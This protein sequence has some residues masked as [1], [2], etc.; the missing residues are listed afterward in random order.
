MRIADSRPMSY[1]NEIDQAMSNHGK[2]LQL[3]FLLLP[4]TA[5]ELYGA[6]K[7]KCAVDYGI[8][9]QCFVAKNAQK[10]AGPLRSIVT[11]VVIQINAKLGGQPWTVMIP[12]KKLMV[13]GFDVYHCGKRRGASVGAMVATF[14]E[15]AHSKDPLYYSSVNFHNS[16]DELSSNLCTD[17]SK[18]LKFFHGK[19]TILPDRIIMYRDGVGEGQLSYVY[20]TEIAQIQVLL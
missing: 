1:M 8:P 9:S 5:V 14:Y 18:C 16:K 3:I 11:K 20:D 2:T 19:T 7:R 4:S 13:V 17:I 12:L 6:V 15:E 10:G